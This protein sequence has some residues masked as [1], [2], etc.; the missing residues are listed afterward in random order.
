MDDGSLDQRTRRPFALDECIL[1]VGGFTRGNSAKSCRPV[2]R[3][4]WF[5]L[6]SGAIDGKD[7]A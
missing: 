4:V 3:G 2:A 7:E 6:S 5:G 1:I